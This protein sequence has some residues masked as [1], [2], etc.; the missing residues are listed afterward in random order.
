MPLISRA[1]LL[2]ATTLTFP[3]Y[4]SS[5]SCGYEIREPKLTFTGYK[6][7]S[8]TGVNGT[9][10]T[11]KHTSKK[12][13]TIESL[14]SS[15]E[16]E[17]ETASISTQLPYRDKKLLLFVFG[18]VKNPGKILGKV[19]HF[20]AKAHKAKAV[21]IMNGVTQ[22]VNF[23]AFNDGNKHSFKGSIDLLQF[24]MKESFKNIQRECEDLHK[25]P[26]GIAKSWSEVGLEITAEI[27]PKACS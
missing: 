9:F 4:A 18:N 26:D 10:D 16:F 6:F 5:K 11:I 3:L 13:E 7:T 25:G 19:T 2:L 15:T 20:D 8:K 12:N 14:I 22:E 27:A 23:S 1:I 17:I 21:L 24:G